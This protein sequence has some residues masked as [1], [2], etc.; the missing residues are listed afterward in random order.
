MRHF[1]RIIALQL[2]RWDLLIQSSL[3]FFLT[4]LKTFLDDKVFSFAFQMGHRKFIRTVKLIIVKLKNGY[5]LSL[6]WQ[7]LIVNL[8]L[9][10]IEHLQAQN[11]FEWSKGCTLHSKLPFVC[12]RYTYY[13]WGICSQ[14]RIDTHIS[15]YH[16][17]TKAK[18]NIKRKSRHSGKKDTQIALQPKR[19]LHKDDPRLSLW[20]LNFYFSFSCYYVHIELLI[21][22]KY[23]NYNFTQDQIN[24]HTQNCMP[25]TDISM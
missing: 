16:F 3:R 19:L 5:G 23:W 10:C 14:D 21:W 2:Y 6:P 1:L 15:V 7:W 11:N 20:K 22:G 9:F 25:K 4:N 24:E 12:R 13:N 8:N 17:C 18:I